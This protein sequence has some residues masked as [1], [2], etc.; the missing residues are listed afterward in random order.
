MILN[1]LH[2]NN[3]NKILLITNKN[4]IKNKKNWI[5]WIKSIIK[6]I[7]KLII[8]KVIVHTRYNNHKI[9]INKYHRKK[10]RIGDMRLI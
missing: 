1:M 4:R 7:I 6:I 5:K 8:N 9:R 3:N 2:P 10:I